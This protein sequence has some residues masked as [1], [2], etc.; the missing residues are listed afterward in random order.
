MIDWPIISS[1]EY[2]KIRSAALFQLMT[3]LWRSLLTMASSE[4]S[5][6]ASYNRSGGM[7]LDF[8][9]TNYSLIGSNRIPDASRPRNAIVT[10]IRHVILSVAQDVA[11]T[12]TSRMLAGQMRED[13]EEQIRKDEGGIKKQSNQRPLRVKGQGSALSLGMA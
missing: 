12:L 9:L 13:R 7:K 1:A 3:I 10:S 4:E 2:P 8:L 5:T 6:M 11:G